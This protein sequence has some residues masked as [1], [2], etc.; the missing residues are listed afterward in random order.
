MAWSVTPYSVPPLL[1]ALISLAVLA[2]AVRHRERPVARPFAALTCA[3]VLWSAA[4]AVQLGYADLGAQLFWQR[5]GVTIAA[6]IPPI[7]LAL[8]LQYTDR[9]EWLAGP[10][11]MLLAVD[12]LVFGALVWSNPTHELVWSVAGF[13]PAAA[14]GVV[15]LALGPAYLAH[16]AYAYL[17]VL[18]GVALIVGVVLRTTAVHRYQAGL[19][20][21]GAV[22]PLGANVAFT[23]G[24][25]PTPDVDFTTFAFTLT[26]VVFALALFRFDLLNLTP[27]A[28]RS[29]VEE[30]DDGL[31]VLDADGEVTDYNEHATRILEAGL[32]V[33]R[34][35][36]AVFPVDRL[37]AVDGTVVSA[38]MG[39]T[40]YF[41]LRRSA[42]R[43]HRG[44]VA[45]WAVV[46]RDVTD[47]KAY[48]QRLEVA[49]RLLRHNLR[50]DMTV[51]MGLA[52]D[53]SQG[54]SGEQAERAAT[55]RD[56]AADVATLGEKARQMEATMH[57][58]SSGA[59]PVEAAGLVQRCVERLRE[60]YPA[61]TVRTD[62][63]EAAWGRV[64]DEELL[65]I[66]V[67][68][69]V[70]NAIEH[71]DRAEPTVRVTVREDAG[72]V[73]VE[74]ADDGPGIPE[75]EHAV[76]LEGEETQLR[77]GSGV[78][79]WIVHWIV[80]AAGGEARFEENEPR[81][82]VVTL[83][84]PVADPAESTDAG[85]APQSL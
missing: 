54:L 64:P 81:G 60:R 68:N 40:R 50:N 72:D 83:T 49:N 45:G 84:V 38:E 11:R 79:L 33:G 9:T 23:L 67:S 31:V 32:A 47:A 26:G 35:A 58:G 41:R 80:T 15:E 8:A 51:I 19:L 28:H 25:G 16:I 30:M 78:G 48:E 57:H 65:G 24:L 39:R 70:E 82:S 3:I 14:P 22:V 59:V 29:V 17:L 21:L 10:T 12:P 74:V 44:E 56:T 61:A 66:A 27:V 75:Q 36:T 62:V 4:Y 42:L 52:E 76:L 1:A 20:A 6:L 53:L 37:S 34:P 7:W 69:V 13:D 85:R 77:H 55:I 18:A 43:D 73:A 2:V 46:M 5:V 71:S 63:P